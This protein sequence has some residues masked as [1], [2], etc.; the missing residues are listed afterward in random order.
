ARKGKNEG[1]DMANW[2]AGAGS[3]M[4]GVLLGMDAR[5]RRIHNKQAALANSQLLHANKYKL[6]ALNEQ[7]GIRSPEEAGL[8]EDLDAIIP[9]D[10][11]M[12]E[13]PFKTKL[14]SF[15]K[16]IKSLVEKMG[17]KKKRKALDLGGEGGF[18]T[19]NPVGTGEEEH[20]PAETYA[21]PETDEVEVTP[22]ADGG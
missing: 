9:F 10:E 18:N 3:F 21:L 2:G 15:G 6:R 8:P 4:E 1:I 16:G 13:D 12:P 7:A 22:F 20:T 11:T 17:G 19:S 5:D 14:K